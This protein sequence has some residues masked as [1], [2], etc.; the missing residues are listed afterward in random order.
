MQQRQVAHIRKAILVGLVLFLGI[1][2]SI[3][4]FAL[5]GANC[6]SQ[7]LTPIGSCQFNNV[8]LELVL[9][10]VAAI[11]LLLELFW[12]HDWQ[13]F[14]QAIRSN[15]LVFAF[16]GLAVTSLIWSILFSITLGKVL[17]LIGSTILAIYIGHI[18]RIEKIIKSL[19]WFYLFVCIAS[20]VFVLFLPDIGIMADP[21]YQGA[22]NGIF[23][24][25]N[26]LGCFM[27]LGI[28]IFLVNLIASKKPRKM[29][30]YL[31]L[32]M[33]IFSVF[34][35]IKSKSA[36]GI[37]TT[38][39][40]V[41]LVA[42]LFAWIKWNNK[43]KPVNYYGFGCVMVAAVI[44]LFAKLQ[45]FLGLLGRNTSL[46][47]RVPMWGYL[48]QHLINQR[49]WLGYGYGAIW[50]LQGIR[51]ELAQIFNWNAPVLIADN[52]FID[53]LLHLGIIGIAVLVSLIVLGF[54]RGIKYL[55]KER[56][57]EAAIPILILTFGLIANITL[58]LILETETLVW[59]IALATLTSIISFL[60]INAGDANN[61]GIPHRKT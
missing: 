25:R 43:L 24:H 61:P 45:F 58:S 2:R 16:V 1:F 12:D 54:I 34:L 35:L 5:R 21:F 50:H 37:I 49:P 42:V 9:W 31:N 29:Y 17:V 40:L 14:S 51:M 33:L 18:Y 6:P 41:G 26:Y 53:I 38:F 27:A 20:V 47:G 15:W 11:L 52:G 59:I 46:T 13:G 8:S 30:F 60:P 44:F 55:L 56:T 3:I 48:F 19:V 7:W 36:T 39:V 10:A 4:Y 32:V 28:V 23:W 22:W 57:L